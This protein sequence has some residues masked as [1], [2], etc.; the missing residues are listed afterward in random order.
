M[1]GTAT[2]TIV[3]SSTIISDI[4]HRTASAAPRRG[5]AEA[6]MVRP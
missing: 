4:A 2:A 6:T 1:A 3:L 5:N